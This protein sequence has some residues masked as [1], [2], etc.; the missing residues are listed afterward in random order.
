MKKKKQRTRRE[1]GQP[2]NPC[3]AIILL[4]NEAEKKPRNE[5]KKL[6]DII[7]VAMVAKFSILISEV[8]RV[9]VN[10][11]DINKA[12]LNNLG[13][14]AAERKCVSVLFLSL[15][16]AARKTIADKHPTM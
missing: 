15:G 2:K 6:S 1:K 3:R 7:A 5:W 12:L 14:A 10:E 13:R 16:T 9:V 8:L 4:W 11:A